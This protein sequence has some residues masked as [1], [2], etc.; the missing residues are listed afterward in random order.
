[1]PWTGSVWIVLGLGLSLAVTALT[2]SWTHVQLHTAVQ[3]EMMKGHLASSVAN[4]QRGN[5]P[6]AQAHAAHPLHE[7]Y[8]HAFPVHF[9][10]EHPDVAAQLRG[11]LTRLPRSV[12]AS[13]EAGTYHGEVTHVEQLLDQALTAVVPPAVLTAPAFQ[14][15]VMAKL[16]EEIG[17]EYSAAIKHGNVVN[18]PEYQ[19]AFGF[20]QR[21]KI[22]VKQLPRHDRQLVDALAPLEAALPAVIPP[23]RP[24]PAPVVKQHTTALIKLLRA[25]DR[26]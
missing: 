19:D 11:A 26:P 16:L 18:L 2:A 24:T 13:A 23:T 25:R 12:Q 17:A 21:V 7:H 3:V 15:V 22:L 14:A 6:L 8:Q 9:Q 10:H 1:M 20:L 4:Y 5:L